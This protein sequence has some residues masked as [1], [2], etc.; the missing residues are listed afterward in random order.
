VL[1]AKNSS[2]LSDR[3][4]YLF[5]TLIMLAVLSLPAESLLFFFFSSKR[6]QVL[7]MLGKVQVNEM[8]RELI[9]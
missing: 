1:E 2:T 5:F 4:A 3:A 6:K 9:D 8:K 7:R